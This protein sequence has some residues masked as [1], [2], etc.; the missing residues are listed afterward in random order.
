MT[1]NAPRWEF[2]SLYAKQRAAIFTPVRI[3]IVEASTKS[4][5][6]VGC[7]SWLLDRAIQRGKPGRN[8]W[9]VAP[10][11]PQAKIAY[12]RLC[13]MLR[14]VDSIKRYWQQNRTELTITLWNGAV[15]WFKGS[16]KP[17]S[18]Y[19]EEVDGAVIDEGSRCKEEAWHAV[20]STLTRTRGPVRIIGNVKGKTNWAYLLGVKAKCG[21]PDMAYAKIT[22]YD[23]VE[24]GVLDAAEIESAKAVLPENVFRELYLAEPSD[25]GGNPFGLD[26]IL[27][28]VIPDWKPGGTV[29]AWGVDLAKSHDWTVAIG[30]DSAGRCVA[31]QRWQGD[32]RATAARLAAMLKHTPALVDS[33]GVG[34]PIVEQLQ[35][36][37]GATDGYK[38]T[39]QSKQQLM[40]GL[41]VAIQQ[42]QVGFPDGVIVHELESYQYEYKAGGRVCYTAPEGM[43]DDT[44]CALALAVRCLRAGP[45][46]A[47]LRVEGYDGAHD[48]G[49]D[50]GWLT[51]ENEAIWR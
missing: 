48:H 14:R 13:R 18:L 39:S 6:T 7:M 1:D 15:L 16:D 24:A 19:G 37:C 17:D 47:S 5:K 43:H 8:Y 2:P 32:W 10:I 27:R 21:E 30:L 36:R 28:C 31:F 33:T 25:D 51:V 29:A 26:A 38:F 12:R 46:A 9:W 22:A 34:D 44:V 40:E 20:R 4:G 11:F 42:R 35:A 23:A 3:A 45:T 50:H 41:A 49:F